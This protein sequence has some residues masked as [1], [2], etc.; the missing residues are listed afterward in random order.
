M[1]EISSVQPFQDYVNVTWETGQ[2]SIFYYLWLRDNDPQI[3]TANGQRLIETTSLALEMH[4][5]NVQWNTHLEIAWEDGTHSQFSAEWLWQYA[6]TPPAPSVTLWDGTI[7]PHSASYP[8]LIQNR[9]ALREWLQHVQTYGFAVLHDVPPQDGMILEVVSLF[10]YV[11]ETNYGKLF[12]VKS[13]A[14]P[15]NLAFTSLALSV[16]TDNPYRD[17]V[18]TL[19]LLHCLSSDLNG[20]DS[21]LVDGF[22]A[23]EHLRQNYPAD[24]EL[25]ATTPV[26]FRFYDEANDIATLAPLIRVDS[27][28][29]ITGIRYNN[30]SLAPFRLQPKQILPYY[31]A[32][33]RFGKLLND[34]RYQIQFRMQAGD[35]FIVDNERVLHGR[36]GFD[37]SG[38]RHLQGCYADRDGLYSTLAVLNRSK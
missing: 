27:T 17:P 37:G 19:Q 29:N 10:G 5:P 18:P 14:N 36:S 35:L 34:P 16:H 1:P 24:F 31:T 15:N 32:Y 4:P 38:T 28:G 12:D 21:I 25:L 3:K 13:V 6:A 22:Y 9:M 7:S 8:E 23:A 33:Q 26:E 2:H 11:R 30:R 20:G